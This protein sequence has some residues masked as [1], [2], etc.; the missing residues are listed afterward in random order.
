MKKKFRY[1]IIFFLLLFFLLGA[2]SYI[3][4]SPQIKTQDYIYDLKPSTSIPQVVAD[5]ANQNIIAHP[6]LFGWYA[7]LHAKDKLKAGEYKFPIGATI[8]A[9]WYQITH[10]KGLFYRSFII[11]PGWTFKQLKENL[12]KNNNLKHTL[13]ELSD[14]Q[15]ISLLGMTMP[16]EGQ[17]LPETYFYTKGIKDIIILQR[18]YALMQKT[19]QQLW[20]ERAPDLIYKNEYEALIA[21]SLI[22]KEAFLNEERPRI[23]GVLLNRL[24]K[25]MLLQF[26]PTVIYGMGTR[27]QGKIYQTD[28]MEDTPYNTYIHKGLPPT[29]IALA[30]AASLY[31]ALHPLVH[32]EYY[33]VARGNGSHQFSENLAAHQKAVLVAI[34]TQTWYFN[35][36]KIKKHL[37]KLLSH[38][39]WQ[40]HYN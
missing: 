28:L 30:S 5:L 25:N 12:L 6:K 32:N 23:A 38:G 33:F 2:Y 39:L 34:H 9:M 19:L 26:D 24:R 20:I 15:I 22:E 16:L 18:S 14:E 10:G 21:A 35:E 11:V 4:L 13:Q 7:L 1:L 37:L 17:F 8:P 27:Y 29:P 40:I 3:V 36:L 31:A